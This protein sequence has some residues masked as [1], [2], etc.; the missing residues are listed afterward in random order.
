MSS[1]KFNLFL[2][3]GSGDDQNEDEDLNNDITDEVLEDKK[4][5]DLSSLHLMLMEIQ[6]Q[7]KFRCLMSDKC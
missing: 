6:E 4:K 7:V 2:R 1:S 3:F 5:P